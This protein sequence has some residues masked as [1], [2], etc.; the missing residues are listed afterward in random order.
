MGRLSVRS[1]NEYAYMFYKLQ[2]GGYEAFYNEFFS[3]SKAGQADSEF[4]TSKEK[5]DITNKE[6][7]SEFISDN[8]MSEWYSDYIPSFD[9]Y[10]D[11]ITKYSNLEKGTE[12]GN[13]N[14]YDNSILDDPFIKELE[15]NNTVMDI[16]IQNGEV[17][18]NMTSDN[19]Y[20]EGCPSFY[21]QN[22][23]FDVQGTSSQGYPRRNY[24]GKFK[25]RI[26]QTNVSVGDP[27]LGRTWSQKTVEHLD[28]G[29]T[30][31]TYGGDNGLKLLRNNKGEIVEIIKPSSPPNQPI[32]A[33]LRRY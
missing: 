10:D 8:F 28:N 33:V 22:V 15:K 23:Q 12:Y 32:K 19:D 13:Q 17:I 7:M 31:V 25:Q 26:R 30:R 24:K 20:I 3:N 11:S 9:E 1:I 27:V 4:F 5:K 16:L 29:L 14:Y 6:K 18:E 2:S 21:A